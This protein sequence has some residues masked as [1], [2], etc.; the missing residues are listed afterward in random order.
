VRIRAVQADNRRR[1]FRVSTDRGV[2]DFPYVKA[3]P[4]P[5]PND[6]VE[7][8]F[9]DPELGYQAFTYRLESGVEDSIHLESV[10]EYN[11]DPAIL[12]ELLLHRLTL[13]ARKAIEASGLSKRELIRR[14]GTSA[15]QL[16][17]LLD[18]T[19]YSKSI[20]QMLALLRVLG[21]EVDVVVR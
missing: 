6:R 9:P 16:Y 20:D 3:H 8:V 15:S 11:R 12:N 1:A 2:F 17:R 10:L 14:L 21:K 4:A 13:E 5:S 18:T 7:D 19:N